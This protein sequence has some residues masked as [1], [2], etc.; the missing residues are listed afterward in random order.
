MSILDTGAHFKGKT[1][2]PFSLVASERAQRADNL[3]DI[4]ALFSDGMRLEGSE[5]EGWFDLLRPLDALSHGATANAASA[6]I[7]SDDDDDALFECVATAALL[8]ETVN[9]EVLAPELDDL[10]ADLIECLSAMDLF[11]E[12][13]SLDD[14]RMKGLL[15]FD[16]TGAMLDCA[17]KTCSRA[18]I[19][20]LVMTNASRVLRMSAISRWSASMCDTKRANAAYASAKTSSWAKRGKLSHETTR[21]ML[22]S[23]QSRSATSDRCA[24]DRSGSDAALAALRKKREPVDTAC[25]RCASSAPLAVINPCGCAVFCSACVK[26][27]ELAGSCRFCSAVALPPSDAA[28]ARSPRNNTE[29]F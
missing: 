3:M 17:T 25:M 1:V 16:K 5:H 18:C 20:K 6:A 12:M 10:D 11:A 22:K 14:P 15:P 8:D 26:T 13:P 23:P 2:W 19:A 4:A 24:S 9:G 21:A 7:D 28:S 29:T 27:M